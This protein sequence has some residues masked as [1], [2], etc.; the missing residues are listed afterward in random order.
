MGLPIAL[1]FSHI[2]KIHIDIPW[3]SLK[4]KNTKIT[5]K[6]IYALF[7]INYEEVEEEIN[8]SEIIKSMMERIRL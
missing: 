6:G 4:D 1:K 7:N 3:T 5:V 2:E 8:A